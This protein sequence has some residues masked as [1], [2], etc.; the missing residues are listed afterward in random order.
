MEDE[1]RKKSEYIDEAIISKGYNPEDLSNF[2]RREIYL[3]INDIS[4][5]KLKKMI[6]KFKDKGLEDIYKSVKEQDN[7]G[8]SE[9]VEDQ[10]YY[11]EV[12]DIKTKIP[13]DN[14]LLELEKNNKNVVI[15][16]SEANKEN[17]GTFFNKNES[18][19]KVE[20]EEIKSEVYR[21]YS[22]FE[23]LRNEYVLFYPL[24]IIP[25]F[26]KENNLVLEGIINKSD[27][28]NISKNKKLKYLN[29]YIAK[30]I[31]KKSFRTSS[32][33]FNFVTLCNEEFKQYKALI[34]KI[35]FELNQN[36]DNFKK[37]K[38]NIHCTFNRDKISYVEKISE[39]F[40][41]MSDVY[42]KLED[43]LNKISVDLSDLA[44]N[45]KEISSRFQELTEN[46]KYF[47]LGGKINSLYMQLDGIFLYWSSSLERQAQFFNE[48]FKQIF[49]SFNLEIK[50]T[51]FL[52]K[53]LMTQKKNYETKGIKLRQRKEELFY[54]GDINKWGLDPSDIKLVEKNKKEKTI[55][56][57]KMLN[58]ETNALKED[59]KRL[60]IYIHLIN[61]QFDKLLKTQSDEIIQF[62]NELKNNYKL[63]VG[64]TYNII[65]LFNINIK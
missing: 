31:T 30:L 58:K 24:R 44:Y 63:M 23:W 37:V 60:A 64:D 13:K 57:E 26:I 17:L 42:S 22:D 45:M 8:E 28:E 33:L 48:D 62:F 15:K 2:I 43:N 65:K 4:F 38:G 52:Q 9:N 36:F 3:G 51:E 1:Q 39:S 40:R 34:S 54:Q 19:Y 32:L 16:I 29:K 49:K 25:P 59:K 27:N 35:K 50:E 18:V 10:L 21:T 6:D 46:L 5:D 61:K 53:E 47:R 20:C 55:C 11:P 14:K 12:Y 56:F 7:E 41:G